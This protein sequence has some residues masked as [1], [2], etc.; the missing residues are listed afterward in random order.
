[1]MKSKVQAKMV[2]FGSYL[3]ISYWIVV[4]FQPSVSVYVA[5]AEVQDI[6]SMHLAKNSQGWQQEIHSKF[7]LSWNDLSRVT[8]P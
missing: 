5:N 8:C 3:E 4:D 1:M 6:V 2:S 7:Y